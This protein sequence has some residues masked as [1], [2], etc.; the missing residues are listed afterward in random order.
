MLSTCLEIADSC[1]E[2]NLS[3]RFQIWTLATAD[4]NNAYMFALSGKVVFNDLLAGQALIDKL[5]NWEP[6]LPKIQFFPGSHKSKAKE[7]LW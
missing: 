3:F 2:E 7:D 6:P 1:S 4:P 5:L